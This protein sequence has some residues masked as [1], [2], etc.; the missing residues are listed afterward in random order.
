MLHL[1]HRY[2]AKLDIVTEDD[3]KMYPIHWAARE[4][5]L[6][7]LRF[8]VQSGCDMNVQDKN[9]CTPI[10]FAAQHNKLVAVVFLWK[11]GA[12]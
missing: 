10:V 4:G 12:D 8:L 9:G 5:R 7:A 3:A 6:A 11:N 1:I 2:G